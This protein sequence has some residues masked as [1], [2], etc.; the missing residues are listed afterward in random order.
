MKYFN[1][2]RNH[3]LV[4]SEDI[5]YAQEVLKES[6]LDSIT[7]SGLEIVMFKEI[8]KS[9]YHLEI[10]LDDDKYSIYFI[11]KNITGSGW[12]SKPKIRRIQ[13]PNLMVTEL[14]TVKIDEKMSLNMII[15]YYNFDDNPIFVGWD[16]YR[17]YNHKTLRSCYV[18]VDSLK[19]GYEKNFYEGVDSSQKIWIFTLDCF[20]KYLKSY[21]DYINM[22]GRN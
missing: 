22:V 11:L 12:I 1:I 6:I 4:L 10:I 19:R 18:S 13:V 9:Q 21:L 17:Y 14:G 15:G 16:A 7:I 20:D 2:T 3:E 5:K 8:K